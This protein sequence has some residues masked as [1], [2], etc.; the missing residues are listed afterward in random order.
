MTI[1]PA[2]CPVFFHRAAHFSWRAFTVKKRRAYV[3]GLTIITAV[4]NNAPT[5]TP[6]TGPNDCCDNHDALQFVR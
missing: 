2:I 5:A 4:L 3:C 1:F 6:Q